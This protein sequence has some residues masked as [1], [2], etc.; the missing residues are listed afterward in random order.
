MNKL[1]SNNESNSKTNI[2]AKIFNM[3]LHSN[4]LEKEELKKIIHSS[5][6]KTSE[7][8]SFFINRKIITNESI[9]LSLINKK[10]KSLNGKLKY[11][12][13]TIKINKFNPNNFIS[14]KELILETRNNLLNNRIYNKSNRKK[15][16]DDSNKNKEHNNYK[17]S[18]K[19]RPQK[20]V[21]KINE[22]IDKNYK[23]H[24][25]FYKSIS[26]RRNF[27][28]HK[29][30]QQDKHSLYTILAKR[31]NQFMEAFH[32]CKDLEKE[33]L[34]NSNKLQFLTERTP[35]ASFYSKKNDIRTYISPN[36]TPNSYISLLNDDYSISEKIRFQKIMS[37]LTKVKNCVE[38]K[39]EKE[40]DIVKEFLLSIG[41]YQIDHLC[42]EKI[43]NFL[44][45]I[46]EDFIINPSKNMKENILDIINGKNLIRPILSDFMFSNSNI[47]ESDELINQNNINISV[48]KNKKS[49]RVESVE[50]IMKK[51]YFEVKRNNSLSNLTPNQKIII[52]NYK[53]IPHNLKKQEEIQSSS[54]NK[55]HLDLVS[56]PQFIIDMI[57][58]KFKNQK[59]CIFNKKDKSNSNNETNLNNIGLC[60]SNDYNID[61]I[62]KRN[63]LTEYVCLMKAKNNLEI[64]KLKEKYNLKNI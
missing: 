45:F 44:D 52:S 20:F 19:L 55:T 47:K 60:D 25:G 58:K 5:M 27:F 35:M 41:L 16:K 17:V 13:R 1:I 61:E 8:S 2:R 53:S 10:Y 32:E 56:H 39:P 14:N 37:K 11:I 18:Y 40:Y 51:K 30:P 33:F 43:K 42:D 28:Y 64:S 15:I 34:P 26:S 50:R 48:K 3:Q 63:M 22:K 6:N 31:K 59:K 21:N 29:L 49:H 7:F 57:E 62:R 12:S 9:P 4:K 36:K 24:L 54:K 23:T 46:K 38:E